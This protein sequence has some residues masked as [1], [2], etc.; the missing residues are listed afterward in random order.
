MD[1]PAR[2]LILVILERRA[3]VGAED[4]I[5]GVAAPTATRCCCLQASTAER[6]PQPREG[7]PDVVNK[8]AKAP[9]RAELPSPR[10][11]A[12]VQ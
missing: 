6:E 2:A 8:A 4:V 11:I 5:A 1:Q 7:A 3:R 12:L 10:T 9:Q